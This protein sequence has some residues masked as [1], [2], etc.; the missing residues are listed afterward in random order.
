MS[1]R[2]H[3]YAL[4]IP[5]IVLGPLS[6]CA[7]YARCGLSGCAG[8]AKITANVQALIDQHPELGPNVID[9]QTL[10][11]VVYLYGLVDTNLERQLAES[12]ALNTPGVAR[13]VNSIATNN[14]G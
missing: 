11:H 13:V 10:D 7:T 1:R 12:A 2:K 3:L 5:L 4:A 14:R 6:G 8:D 9:V